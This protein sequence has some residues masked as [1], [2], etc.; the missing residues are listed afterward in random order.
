MKSKKITR[1][2]R[3][4]IQKQTEIKRIPA[5][6]VSAAATAGY[7]TVKFSNGQ[8]ADI[9]NYRVG[10]IPNLRVS[11]G[12]DPV[13]PSVLQVL[14]PRLVFQN[15]GALVQYMIQDHHENHEWPGHD[16]VWVEGQQFMPMLVQPSGDSDFIVNVFEGHLSTPTTFV[17]VLDQTVD[18]TAYQPE[19]GAKYVLLQV[20]SSGTV[21]VKLGSEVAVKELL[22]DGDIPLPDSGYSPLAAIRLYVG[23]EYIRCDATFNDIVDLRFGGFATAGTGFGDM[24]KSVYDPQNISADA[25]DFANMTGASDVMQR[26]TYDPR[27]IA[28]DVFVQMQRSQPATPFKGMFWY[29]TTGDISQA[30]IFTTSDNSMYLG[31]I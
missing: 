24:L 9:F 18:L 28:G 15:I 30:L 25:F 20:N 7:T 6:I 3:G 31:V 4:V 5:T 10:N 16:T 1:A 8:T 21:S 11:I 14:G 22:D 29:N 26:P 19:A 23:Q 17:H 27:H 13:F 12:T 2:I